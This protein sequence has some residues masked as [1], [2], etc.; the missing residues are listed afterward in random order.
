MYPKQT[1]SEQSLVDTKIH[2][3]LEA[4]TKMNSNQKQDEGNQDELQRET[5]I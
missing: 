1:R 3:K 5:L 4:E 2:F